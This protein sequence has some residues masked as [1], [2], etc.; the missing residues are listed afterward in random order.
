MHFREATIN[1]IKELQVIRHLV[2]ENTLSDPSLVT[3]AD[4]ARFLTTD[5]KGWVCESNGAIAGFAIID[6]TGNNIW[7]LF[8]RPEFEKKGMGKRLHDIM[9]DWYF[10]QSRNALWLGTAPNTRAEI[11]YRR[12]GWIETGRRKN[13]EIKFEMSYDDWMQIRKDIPG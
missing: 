12:K 6:T 4:C 11:F 13:G 7:A 8:M 1:D 9:L 5:G 10:N 2:K 3:D